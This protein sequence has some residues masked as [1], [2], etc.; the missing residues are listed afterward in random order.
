VAVGSPRGVISK[1]SGLEGFSHGERG[2]S[3]GVAR[4][5]SFSK[6][7]WIDA[8]TSWVESTIVE[9]GRFI[10]EMLAMMRLFGRRP[11][12]TMRLCDYGLIS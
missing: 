1:G 3:G 2:S 9:S 12:L 10:L 5:N 7:V 4:V 8:M 11:L 6:W